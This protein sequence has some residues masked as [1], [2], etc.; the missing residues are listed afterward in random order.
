MEWLILGL[1]ITYTFTRF[2]VGGA[3]STLNIPSLDSWHEKREKAATRLLAHPSTCS[4]A[5]SSKRTVVQFAVTMISPG[6]IHP[7]LSV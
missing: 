6:T 1:S 5:N 2:F 4:M 3:Q 7:T